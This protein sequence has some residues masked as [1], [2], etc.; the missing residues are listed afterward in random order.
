M[1][2]LV[3]NYTIERGIQFSRQI[4]ITSGST[5]VDLTGA[6]VSA[7]V[8]TSRLP[9]DFRP[10]PTG[11]GPLITSFDFALVGLATAGRFSISLTIAKTLL[12]ARGEYDYDVIITFADSSKR[13][14][15]S[16]I[17]TAIETTTHG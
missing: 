1:A 12:L 2:A 16:G 13:R 9:T 8:R 3:R 11:T 5:P 17:L 10:F 15:I 7:Q 6:T 4:T 14:I